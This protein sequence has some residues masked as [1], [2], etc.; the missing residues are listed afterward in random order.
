MIATAAL[1][2]IATLLSIVTRPM[3][4]AAWVQRSPRLAVLAW[5]T[6]S[7]T[8]LATL[9]LAGLT[10]LI[11]SSSLS[12][13]LAEIFDAC[14]LTVRE[15]YGSP[16]Q[17]PGVLVGLILAVVLPM[18]VLWCAATAAIRGWRRRRYLRRLIASVAR[19]DTT[20]GACILEGL[21]AAVFCVPGKGGTIV[22]TAAALR[23]LTVDE[24]A[25]VL[26][27]ERA[28]LR[29]R[30]DIAVGASYALA[31]A[32][33][34]WRIFRT[35]A[36][37][38]SALVEL[39]ADD[40]AAREVDRLSVASALVTLAGMRA[41]AAALPA[42]QGMTAVRVNRL[43]RPAQPLRPVQTALGVAVGVLGLAVPV[44]IAGVPLAAAL[45]SGLCNVP[46]VSLG[47]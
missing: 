12:G 18:R 13:G 15:V 16:G 46:Q 25:G 27:H 11:P 30:H 29:G 5:Q 39:L 31:R 22:V 20:L 45:A 7:F 36:A 42:A 40:A 6:V 34:F 38:I 35:A 14:V 19:R 24:V 26:A 28:H 8:V 41:P 2:S 1:L 43:L 21:S 4:G 17:L 33:P 47:W 3:S 9:A 32:L 10:L 23:S 44:V 37:E